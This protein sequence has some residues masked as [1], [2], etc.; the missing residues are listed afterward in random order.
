MSPRF[1]STGYVTYLSRVLFIL[2]RQRNS[3]ITVCGVG[4]TARTNSMRAT[5]VMARQGMYTS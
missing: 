4:V 2:T 3:C 1:L 5:E